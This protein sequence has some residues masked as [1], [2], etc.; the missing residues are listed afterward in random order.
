VLAHI[1]AVVSDFVVIV[2]QLRNSL[3]GRFDRKNGS[4]IAL[5]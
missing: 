5:F 4:A 1:G 2:R 3:D